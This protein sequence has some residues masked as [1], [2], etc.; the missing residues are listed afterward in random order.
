MHRKN[1]RHVYDLSGSREKKVYQ[2]IDQS[3]PLAYDDKL[4]FILLLY[5]VN[6][7]TFVFDIREWEQS[8]KEDTAT[9]LPTLKGIHLSQEAMLRLM[10]VFTKIYTKWEKEFNARKKRGKG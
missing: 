7:K 10:Q 2:T 4:L 5:D 1:N 6:E 3:V 8:D 9:F